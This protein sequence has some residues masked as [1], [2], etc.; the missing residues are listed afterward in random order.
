[1]T[2]KF[3]TGKALGFAL[4]VFRARPRT[5]IILAVWTIVYGGVLGSLQLLYTGE[6]MAAYAARV[7][8][9]SA[10]VNEDPAAVLAAMGQYFSSIA[11][12]AAVALILGI[13]FECAWLR[14]FVRGQDGGLFPFRIGRDEAV[15][16]ISGVMLALLMFAVLLLA[17]IVLFV[18]TLLLTF[19]G[20]AGAMIA[21]GV[22][23]LAM[24]GLMIV[25]LTLFSPVLALSILRGRSAVGA[26]IRG[27]RQ[28]FWPLLGS[29]IVTLVLAMA[30]YLLFSS[31][32]A[33]MPFDQFGQTAPGQM[34]AW[35]LLFVY[36]A[37]VQAL[38]VIPAALMRGVAS[39]AALQIDEANRPVSDTFS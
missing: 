32:M 21:G 10:G 35:P 9:A 2:P 28:V 7:T 24:S 14:L 31:V 3:E 19:A 37:F 4:D 34:A 26:G 18:I 16:T 33:V 27:A 36:F 17:I 5:F 20:P 22:A 11:P 39:Y 12:F 23:L 25:I 6:D 38:N 8:A 29:L 13:L 1:M 15:Y 30:A